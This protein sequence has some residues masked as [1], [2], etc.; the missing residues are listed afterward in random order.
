M[1]THSRLFK[2]MAHILITVMW[3]QPLCSLAA[4]LRVDANAGGNTQIMQAGNGVPIVKIATPNAKGLSHNKFTDYNVDKQGLILNNS[5]EKLTPTYLG[6]VIIGNSQLNGQAAQLILNEVSGGQASQLKGYTEVAGQQAHVVVANPHGITC[7]GCGFINTPHVTLSTGKPILE[8]GHL[9]RYEVDSGHIE[10]AGDGLNATN[11][12]QFDLITRSATINAELHANE[13]NIITGR[14]TVDAQTLAV[15]VKAEHPEDKPSLAI[16]SSAL[17][18]MYAGAIRL[19]GTE[20]GVGVKLAGD[21]ATH[22]GDIQIDTKGQL[23]LARMSTAQQLKVEAQDIELTQQIYAGDQIK[24]QAEKLT[25]QSNLLAANDIELS[26]EQVENRGLIEAGLRADHRLNTTADVRIKSTTLNNS[27]SVLASHHLELEAKEQ[28][29]NQAGLLLA[30]TGLTITTQQ[31]DN[32]QGLVTAA[33]VVEV[34]AQQ[35]DNRKQGELSS[36]QQLTVQAQT[37]DNREGGRLISE[38]DVSVTVQGLDNRQ[39]GIIVADKNLTIGAGNIDNSAQGLLK[40]TQSL[41]ITAGTLNNQDGGRVLSNAGLQLDTQQLNN[42]D[43]FLDTQGLLSITAQSIDNTHGHIVADS[44]VG[45]SSDRLDNQVDGLILSHGELNVL[46]NRLNNQQGSM[47]ADAGI[48]LKGQA[49]NND[50]GRI[51]SQNTVQLDYSWLKN[52]QGL[53]AAGNDLTIMAQTTDNVQGELSAGQ[54]LQLD[55][56]LLQQKQGQILSAGTMQLRAE[57]LDNSEQGLISAGAD[58][59]IQT[60]QLDNHLQ[61]RV[62]SDS[63]LSIQ[64]NQLNNYDKGLLA[65]KG[66]LQADLKQLDQHNQGELI[67]EDTIRLNLSDGDL[68]NSHGGLIYAPTLYLQQV[69]FLNNSQGGEVSSPSDLVLN[70]AQLNNTSARISSGQTLQVRVKDIINNTLEGL[71]SADH[72]L[73]ISGN[74]LDNSQKGTLIAKGDLSVQVNA[75]LNNSQDGAILAGGQLQIASDTLN[76]SQRGAIVSNEQLNTHAR[77]I[78]NQ[79]DGLLSGLLGV[80]LSADSLDNQH[81]GTVSSGAGTLTV[82]VAGSVN[83]SD[84]GALVSQQALTIHAG[85]LENQHGI[86]S[87]EIDVELQIIGNIDNHK[88]Q[89]AGRDVTLNADNLYNTAGHISAEQALT[90]KFIQQL[91]NQQDASIISGEA[92]LLTAGTIHNQNSIIASEGVLSLFAPQLR[93]EQ[94]AIIAANDQLQIYAQQLDNQSQGRIY[95]Q[96]AAV[97]ITADA[98]SNHSALIQ[99]RDGLDLAITQQLV[100]HDGSVLS[101]QGAVS[102]QAQTVDN[103][104]GLLASLFDRLTLSVKGLFDNQF[105]IV[106]G[107]EVLL[108]ANQ[109]ANQS[110]YFAA[111]TAGLEL[112][113]TVLNNQGGALYAQQQLTVSGR[114][115]DNS[116]QGQIAAKRIDFSLTGALNNQAG[117]VEADHLYVLAGSVNNTQGQLRALAYSGDSVIRVSNTFDNRSGS[118]EVANTTGILDA[119]NLLNQSG[120]VMHAGSGPFDL[121][122]GAAYNIGGTFVSRGDVSITSDSWENSTLFQAGGLTLNIDHFKQT[123]EGQLITS[124][125]LTATGT[126]WENEGLIASDGRLH[127]QL[128]GDYSG[129][130]QVVSLGDMQ[131]SAEQFNLGQQAVIYSESAVHLESQNLTNQGYI[132]AGDTLLIDTQRLINQGTLGSAQQLRINTAYLLNDHALIFSGTD[133]I[134]RA[135]QL[136]NRYADVYSLG[137][138][139]LA[140]YKANSHAQRVENISGNFEAEHDFSL[141]SA[142]VE[143]RRDILEVEDKGIYYAEIT[144]LRCG[145]PYIINGDCKL[146]D[147]G[148]RNSVWH[149]TEREKVE[150]INSSAAANLLAGGDFLLSG[151][152]LFNNSSLIG[153]GADLNLSF[154]SVHNLGVKPAD[155]EAQSIHIAGRRPKYKYPSRAA[156]LFNSKHNP[157]VQV[158]SVKGDISSFIGE[159]SEWEYL[160]GRQY[161]EKPLAGEEYSAIIQA[162][163]NVTI[164]AQQTLKNSVIRPSYNYVSGGSRVDT[165]TSDSTHAIQVSV[166]SQVAPDLQHKQIDST[167]LPSF[168]VPAGDKGLFRLSDQTAQGMQTQGADGIKPIAS[169]GSKYGEALA[170]QASQSTGRTILLSSQLGGSSTSQET[171]EKS[172][173]QFMLENVQS[174][175]GQNNAHRYLIETNPALTQMHQFLSSDYLL[176]GLGLSADQMQKRLGDGLYEQKLMSEA[177]VARTGQRF[178]AGLSS[179]E[180]MLRYLMDNALASKD[181]LNLSVG[182]SLSAEQVAALTE[183]I[184]WL[185]ER[186]VL[187]EQVLV[188]V[189]YMA[190]AQGRMAANGALIQ[191]QN[192]ALVS[193]GNLSNQGI[194]RTG[195]NLSTYAQNIN[196]SGLIHA[197]ERLSLLA[198][199]SIYNRQGGILAGRDV[200]LTARTGDILNERTVTRHASAVGNNRRETSF[201]DSAARIESAGDLYL[202]AGRDVQNLG[203]VLA[204]RGDL[205]SRAGR[206]VTLASVEERHSTSRG[207]HYLM[208][209]NQQ[210]GSETLA[211]GNLSIQAGRDLT[212][213]A[214]RIESDKDMQ[215]I[216]AND[217]T[218]ASAANEN[219]YYNKSKRTTQSSDQITQQSSLIHANGNIELRAINDLNITAS[220]VKTANNINLAAGQDV[221]ILSG[222]DENASFYSKKSKGTF[223]RSKSKQQEHYDSTNVAS[224]IDAGNNLT[225]NTQTTDSGGLS[226]EGGRDVTVIGSQLNAGNSLIVSVTNDMSILSGIEEHGSYSKK[227]KSGFLGLNKTGK[228]RLVTTATQVGSD[229]NAINDVVLVAGNDLNLR[230]SA[231]ASGNNIEMYAGLIESTGD[232]NLLSANNHAYDLSERYRKKVG[233]SASGGV[234]S[235]SSA[236]QAGQAAQT[237]TSVGSQVTAEKNAGLSAERDITIVGSAVSAGGHLLLN[238]GRDVQ[239]IAAENK[240]SVNTW[241]RERLVSVAL[242]SDGDGVAAFAG[243]ET[244]TNKRWSSQDTAAASQLASGFDLNVQA[245]RDIR[246]TGSD[247][248]AGRDINLIAEGNIVLDAANEQSRQL[249]KT[250]HQRSGLAVNINHNAVNT[251][252]AV[253][254]AGQG[255]N[256]ISQAS[257]VLKANDSLTQFVSGP[258]AS[259]HLG[260]TRQQTTSTE[261]IQSYRESV[262]VAGRDINLQAGQNVDVRGT[263]MNS[264][265]DISI[266]GGNITLDAA[267][268]YFT[269]SAK[270]TFSK[271]GVN[272]SS[273]SNSARVGLGGSYSNQ[274]DKG[275]QSTALPSQLQAGRDVNVDA[276][277]DLT[278]IGTQ[279]HAERDLHLSAGQD[280]SIHA[281]QNAFSHDT[282]RNSGGGEAGLAVGGQGLIS[283]YASADMGKGELNRDGVHQQEAYLYAGNHLTFNS[284]RDTL[285]A[286]AQLEGEHVTGRVGRD[287][288]MSSVKDTGKVSGKEFDGSVTGSVGLSGSISVSGSLGVGETTG[289]TDWI[290]NQTRIIARDALDIGIE[291]H[292]QIHSALIASNTGNLKLD[293]NTLGFSD[294][295]G[296]DKETSWYVSAG[297]TYAWGGDKGNTPDAHAKGENITDKATGA[298]VVDHSQANKDGSNSWNVSGHLSEKDREQSVRATVGEGEVIV[299]SDAETGQDSLAGLNRDISKAYEITKDEQE[300]TE[301]YLSSS[302]LESINDPKMTFQQWKQGAQAY[303]LNSAKAFLQY[304]LLKNNAATAAENNNLVAALSWAPSLLVD[305]MDMLNKPTGGAFPGVENHGGLAT[306]VPAL[307]VGDLMVYRAKGKLKLNADGKLVIKEGKPILD[308]EAT[309]DSFE[310]FEKDEEAHVSTN[311][312]MNTLLESLINALMQ[313]GMKDGK[314]FV[315]A[316]NPTHGLIGDLI[317]SGFDSLFKGRIKSGVAR[318]LSHLYQQASNSPIKSLHAYGHSQGGLLNWVAVKGQDFSNIEMV[319][320]QVSGAPVDAIKFHDDVREITDK[321]NVTSHFQ[322][323]RPNEKTVFGLPKTDTVADL[324]GGNAKYSDDPIVLTL[325]AILSF[326]SLFDTENSAHSNYGCASCEVTGFTETGRKVRDIVISPTVIDRWGKA[327]KAKE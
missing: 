120:Y 21:M 30:D 11:I 50:D 248:A 274:T 193:A 234:V 103:R 82:H 227:N 35:I 166:N 189:F 284:D 14:N 84:Q 202:A 4:E 303:G 22:A 245:G 213:L 223:G 10:I 287:L 235:I 187:G 310:R 218:L 220:E 289:S 24:V 135:D 324:I 247:L 144:E 276:A 318:D 143:N 224:V 164:D 265:R 311:G 104:K 256:F 273:T 99:A 53:I 95:S 270:K 252:D 281:A 244:K 308:G 23:T 167:V 85:N 209:Q 272:G 39:A 275:H 100:N 55:T 88:G 109:V 163:G 160:P 65:S 49:L 114:Y 59:T 249:E 243:H 91:Q 240:K 250:T 259:V 229:L 327:W 155:I 40:G 28:L 257:S 1:N 183:D 138:I 117:L 293:T 306:Q 42:R 3:M 283:I 17:G 70:A 51:S 142:V 108:T 182:V 131:L 124:D 115:V 20:A 190:Q 269:Q 292:T 73:Y 8:Q 207:N 312:I 133:M 322:V 181:S 113:A 156:L 296:H 178:I 71:L 174:L 261:E 7:D 210:L 241:Q 195:N 15:T 27:G 47:V 271:V 158:E 98:L 127:L 151:V 212:V 305:A 200:D 294:F 236:K 128:R 2:T 233:F 199:D 13:L 185:E 16:D 173:A 191:G 52:S 255:D 239:M 165:R 87:S 217:L 152:E 149:I 313:G 186:E 141:R 278:L 63:M 83:N 89:V 198:Q 154:S 44:G 122:N 110:G 176:D 18:G 320:V 237:S 314:S 67:S 34:H 279:I 116:A 301:L 291:N 58:L 282:H 36:Q 228:S 145:A 286:G 290:E 150:V 230:A 101:E 184:V 105:G 148:K 254:T 123:A 300:A 140:G 153:S 169:S 258:T 130:G 97:K 43:G 61:G 268:G 299:R 136:T 29:S 80:E 129:N 139:D 192:L 216:A 317:E 321:E 177:V 126:T 25:N 102:V 203:G 134:L 90:M 76:N 315:L 159:Y 74:S 92:L 12:S 118:I 295:Q 297:A 304:G 111:T 211:G 204:S 179:D 226:L 157:E 280:L 5:I 188:P 309:F 78:D 93:N 56:R 62:I 147:N 112:S 253:K 19:V 162:G 194:L 72:D 81:R 106:Q 137:S 57:T 132:S 172:Q 69:A 260:A 316:Y 60:D 41:V 201:A 205:D 66:L 161:I 242:S 170:A 238:A 221:H 325:G 263:L 6:G 298:A 251:M 219:H 37:L 9:A 214:S 119:P 46:V 197:D 231:V 208:A 225:I 302:S 266:S 79:H 246:Q 107:Q 125:Y 222:A 75:Q 232:I 68:N 175:Q 323:N 168:S 319:T 285:I 196:N 121:M 33:G 38:A 86:I 277:Q 215:L 264:Q 146:G 326:T 307:A 26:A 262:L 206:D 32:Q 54:T 180:E 288:L 94:Q 171:Y 96:S 31:L 267:L 48:T 45:I 77:Q 64:A